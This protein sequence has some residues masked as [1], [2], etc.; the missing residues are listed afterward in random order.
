M[1]KDQKFSLIP[2]YGDPTDPEVRAKYGYL[3]ATISILGNTLLFILKLYLVLFINSIAL[4]ADGIHSL[5]DVSTSGVVILGFKFAKKPADKEHPYGHGRVEYIAALVIAIFLIIVG[6]SFIERSIGRIL[7]PEE[8]LHQEYLFIIFIIILISAVLKELMARYS[9][10][11]SKKIN[12]DVLRADAWHHRS[13]SLSSIGVAIGILAARYGYP[14]LDPIFGIVVSFIIIYVGIDLIRKTSDLLMG[15]A[16]DKQIIRKIKNTAKKVDG[17]TGLHNIHI[18]DY[19]ASKIITLH[20]RSENDIPLEKAHE[21]ADELEEKI[22]EST[23]CSAIIHL[24]PKERKKPDKNKK[25]IIENM[26]KKQKEIISFYKIQII[27]RSEKDEIKMHLIVDQDMSVERSHDLSHEIETLIREKYGSCNINIH[28][29]P[30]G[31]DCEICD[32]ICR[33]K[34]NK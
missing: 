33:K 12:S 6:I 5:S 11:I 28:F 20:A 27:C 30:C 18:H 8:I 19:G 26:L 4:I 16:P 13:D 10:K 17:V 22:S 24:E 1:S 31:N 25:N 21:I 15:R 23:G 32:R 34:K 7:N 3:E 29:V 14:I 9:Y 2:E